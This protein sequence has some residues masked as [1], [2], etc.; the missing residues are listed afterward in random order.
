MDAL[1]K[2][3][4]I[5]RFHPARREN[6]GRGSGI[7]V[8]HSSRGYMVTACKMIF[9]SGGACIKQRLTT[10]GQVLDRT[11]LQLSK[12]SRSIEGV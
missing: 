12:Q 10:D 7:A 4:E 8:T 5:C 3:F 11:D 6:L 9:S 1:W 2:A